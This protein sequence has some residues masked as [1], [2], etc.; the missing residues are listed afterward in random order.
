[1]NRVYYYIAS[2]LFSVVF[3]TFTAMGATY[4]VSPSGDNGNDGLSA[5][6]PF[7]TIQFAINTAS[8]G[9]TVMVLNGIYTGVGN[10]DIRF[11]G[12]ELIVQS[13]NGSSNVTI[14]CQSAGRGF[15]L[16][17]DEGSGAIIDGLTILNGYSTGNGGGIF[18]D[19]GATPV[20]RNCII[21]SCHSEN[22]GGGISAFNYVTVQNTLIESCVIW[23]CSA[24]KTSPSS[25]TYGGGIYAGQADIVNCTINSCVSSGTWNSYGGGVYLFGGKI[26]RCIIEGC[27]VAS[28]N[29]ISGGG[30][31][32]Q[33]AVTMSNCIVSG[34]SVNTAGGTGGGITA[35]WPFLA[36]NCTVADNSA[37]VAGGIFLSYEK[38][39]RLVNCIV[40]GN[41]AT[42]SDPNIGIFGTGPAIIDY[43]CIEGGAVGTG[44]ISLDPLFI[45]LSASDF[46]LQSGSPCIDAASP[47]DLATDDILGIMRYIADIGAYEYTSGAVY[48]ISG[49]VSGSGTTN[50]TIWIGGVSVIA[51]PTFTFTDVPSGSYQLVATGTGI[52]P[53]PDGWSN[54][55]VVSNANITGC[56]FYMP[57]TPPVG[58]YISTTGHDDTGDGSLSNP[59]RTIQKGVY[60][61]VP[62]NGSVN[63]ISGTYT[64]WW[65]KN[66]EYKGKGILV[67][68]AIGGATAVIDCE[69]NGRGFHVHEGEI[70]AQ[71]SNIDI[72]NGWTLG[73][74]G[75]IL[76]D[77]TG[78]LTMTNCYINNCEAFNGAGVY[79]DTT[80]LITSSLDSCMII[81]NIGAGGYSRG[82]GVYAINATMLNCEVSDNTIQS[83]WGGAGAG[84]GRR[85]S[86]GRAPR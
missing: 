79:V 9:D 83:E 45:N 43:S 53:V 86:G 69:Y 30:V 78:A 5:G 29:E 20:I 80:S 19:A 64:G 27:V 38:Q 25:N 26:E 39:S 16:E 50:A 1:M 41:Q 49:T 37:D 21:E 51:T 15:I 12:K 56:D 7:A 68:S 81:D 10:R 4:Y 35:G 2:V 74:G 40:W 72:I 34:C 75:G 18:V 46:R 82:V 66:I 77:E 33:D 61:A 32:V 58:I 22:A 73:N 70:R 31:Y 84:G 8:T 59:F 17:D 62:P 55:V 6:A 54:P 76:I 14:D 42:T 24:Q 28:T 52:A 57:T 36:L 65:N 71:L 23:K 67:T 48:T 44:N 63:L 47:T 85:C 11:G 13:L 3:L 60:T